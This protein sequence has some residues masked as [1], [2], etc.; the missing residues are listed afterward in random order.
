[1]QSRLNPLPALSLAASFGVLALGLFSPAQS[2]KDRLVARGETVYLN[3]C[4]SCHGDQGSGTKGHKSRLQGSKSQ[5]ELN[6]YILASMPPEG[7]KLTREDADAVGTYIFEAFYSPLARERNRPPRVA[8]SRLTV[9]QHQNVLSDLLSDEGPTVAAELGKGL[10]GQYFKVPHPDDKNRL[11]DRIDERVSFDF[12][13]GG[14]ASEGFDPYRFGA[15]WSGSILAPDSGEYEFVL[16]TNQAGALFVNDMETPLVD[17]RIVSG[18]ESEHRGYLT[19]LGGRT[20]SIR[21]LFSKGTEG[22]QEQDKSRQKPPTPAFVALEWR[23][24][25]MAQEIVPSRFLTPQPSPRRFVSSVPF[26]PDDRS[27]GYDRGTIVS[28]EWN[29]AATAAA[30]EAAGYAGERLLRRFGASEPSPAQ[31]QEVKGWAVAFAQ[32]AFRRP[33]DETEKA[34]LVDRQFSAAPDLVTGLKRSLILTLNS[35]WFLYREAPVES[36]EQHLIAANLSFGL[37]DSLPDE[38]LRQAAAQ[39][40]LQDKAQIRAQAARMAKDPRAWAKLRQFYLAWLR[41]E[42]VPELSKDKMVYPGF[43][44]QV[45]SDLRSSMELYLERTG[46]SESATFG[47]LMLHPEYPINPLLAQ[48]YGVTAPA[49]DDFAFVALNPKERVGLL[50]HPYLLSRLAYTKATSPIHRGVL[51]S[52]NIMGRSLKPPPEAVAPLPVDLHPS[53]TTRER[54][55]LQT[56]SRDCMSCHSLINPLGFTLERFDPIGR[57]RDKD[58]SKKVDSSGSYESKRGRRTVFNGPRDLAVYAAES[59]DS[60]ASFVERLF[61]HLVKQPVRAYGP[62]TLEDLTETFADSGGSI[63]EIVVEILTLTASRGVEKV[64]P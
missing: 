55:A 5:A 1:V 19:L 11:I 6:R 31:V 14:P 37:W 36:R 10:R 43:S 48:I 35:P 52:R 42:D 4:M 8:I 50:G 3:R 51:L 7:K 18:N 60:Q 26:P 62:E 39:G 29:D 56:K 38:E 54:V 47:E 20:Y 25:K 61:H 23:R 49:K 53:L 16:R 46:R 58:G 33:L 17:R 27:I 63:R 40:Q 64:T 45:A 9:R 24:P 30:L 34:R 22:V 59:E 13:T 44:P 57:E 32:K 21:L 41:L 15:L 2:E 12:G 28:R